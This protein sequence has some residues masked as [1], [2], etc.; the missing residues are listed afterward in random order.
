MNTKV[1]NI[2]AVGLVASVT[3]QHSHGTKTVVTTTT[4]VDDTAIRAAQQLAEAAALKAEM[5]RLAALKAEQDRLD[6]LAL[7]AS[8]AMSAEE[9]MEERIRLAQQEALR[10]A[11]EATEAERIRI[12]NQANS[13]ASIARVRAESIAVI[14][15]DQ[16]MEIQRQEEAAARLSAELAT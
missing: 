3:A 11:E 5:E 2:A 12:T 10:M 7:A 16:A 14:A 9:M 4:V 8:T 15:S 1:L 6:A 13:A